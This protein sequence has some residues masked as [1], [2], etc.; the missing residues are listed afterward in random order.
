MKPLFGPPLKLTLMLI[1]LGAEVDARAA[2]P[3][4]GTE[5]FYIGTYSDEIYLSS[6]DLGTKKLGAVMPAGNHT[7]DIS[8]FQPS[9]VALTPIRKF[10]YSPDVNNATVLAHSLIPT[11]GY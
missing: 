5:R 10:L 11:N 6:L 3:S 7:N 4:G 9:F 1:F 2:L 8:S